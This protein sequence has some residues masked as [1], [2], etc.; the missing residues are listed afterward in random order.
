MD[1][2]HFYAL[3]AFF[4]CAVMLYVVYAIVAPFLAPLGWAGV[5]GVLTFPLYRRLRGGVGERDTVASGLMT[6]A[7]VLILVIPFVGL[8]FFLVQE[9]AV[10]YGFLEKIAADGGRA[11]V[12]SIQNH[13]VVR[14][15]LARIEAYTGPLGFE[16]DTRILPGMK[17]VASK[18]LGYSKEIVKN[19]FVFSIKLILMVISLFFI[20]RDGESVQQHVLAIIPLTEANKN[21]LT[22]TVRRVLK[23]VMYG[24]FL[25]CLVQGALGGIGFWAAG[26]PSPLLFGAIM[27]VCALIPVVGTGLIWL[28][29]ALYLLANGEIVKGIGLIVWGFVAVSS[30]DNVIR[31]F[32]ISGKA[33]LPVLVIAIGGLGGLASFGLLGAVIGPIVLAL[34]L[35]LFEMYRGEVQAETGEKEG[36][37]NP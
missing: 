3:L 23:A 37:G 15:W 33:K 7:V 22:D 21:I 26:L 32:F 2:G 24:V 11:L 10:A 14:P 18:V 29:A 31:P 19:V 5:I 16:I 6:P 17:E 8:T 27:A 20:Y 35:A 1:R 12:E 25:T 30:I 34:F 36:R 9:A 4:F 13:P 28:P